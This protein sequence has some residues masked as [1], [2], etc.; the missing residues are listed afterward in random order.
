MEEENNNSSAAHE[1][2]ELLARSANGPDTRERSL[3]AH[4][5]R[6]LADATIV[7]PLTIP[8]LMHAQW[9]QY[10]WRLGHR[11][12]LWIDES[13]SLNVPVDLDPAIGQLGDWVPHVAVA[14][15]ML[16]L[17][18]IVVAR[19]FD[20]RLVR[21]IV[22]IAACWIGTF[23]ILLLDPLRVREWWLD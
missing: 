22:A 13:G 15:L 6:F 23:A 1:G 14:G 10:C 5:L 8:A 18:Y 20:R 21:R 12:R 16:N 17:T 2:D 7:Y 11:P 9:L 4:L 3:V 19:Q